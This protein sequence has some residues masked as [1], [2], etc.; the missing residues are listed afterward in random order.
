MSAWD[1]V[2]VAAVTG[3]VTVMAVLREPSRKAWVLAFPVPFTLAAMA[4]GTRLDA[5]HV[6]ATG[7]TFLYTFLV[8]FV[9]TRLRIHLVLAIGAAVAAF[10]G[11]A[12]VANA[13]LPRGD[14]AFWWAV[15]VVTAAGTALHR[16]LP[17]REE[18]PRTRDLPLAVKVPLAALVVLGL[19]AVKEWIGGFMTMFPM[20][21]VIA[22]VENREGLWS[23]VRRIPVVMTTMMPL[24]V[25]ARITEPYVGLGISLLLGWL[26]FLAT[27]ALMARPRHG[28]A[29]V[30]RPYSSSPR[31]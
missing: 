10:L 21:G 25:T 9:A 17:V 23:N 20:V 26:P 11:T 29:D 31:A 13:V 19:V 15:A 2:L 7:A 14:A 16:S 27:L 28:R 8:W 5:T 12:T 22:S 30:G 24:M 6:V 1:V 3:M 18:L 4:V